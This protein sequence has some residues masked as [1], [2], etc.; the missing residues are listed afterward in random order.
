MACAAPLFLTVISNCHKV[1]RV[2]NY[3]IQG[4]NRTHNNN[5]CPYFIYYT[6][7]AVDDQPSCMNIK[8]DKINSW[9]RKSDHLAI[10]ADHLLIIIIATIGGWNLHHR[11]YGNTYSPHVYMQ[12]KEKLTNDPT[13]TL[14]RREKFTFKD[15]KDF[16]WLIFIICVTFYVSVLPFV[17]HATYVLIISHV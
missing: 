12:A 15:I 3:N 2:V 10:G 6:Y 11:I 4:T 5:Y 14:S 9:P 13:S 1:T 17:V 8:D 16:P 7:L